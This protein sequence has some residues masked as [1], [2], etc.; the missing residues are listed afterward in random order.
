MTKADPYGNP[1]PVPPASQLAV[2]PFLAAV[3]GYLR[4]DQDVPDLRITVHRA[5][6]REGRDYLQQVCAYLRK[7]GGDWRGKV[8]RTFAVDTGII[9]AAYESGQLWRTKRFKDA[10]GLH[11]ALKKDSLSSDTVAQSWLAVPFLGPQDQVVLILYADCNK[12]NFF[13]DD[14][15]VKRIVAMSKGFCR[16]LDWLQKDPFENLRNFPLQKGDP[17]KG[18]G[19][20]YSVQQAVLNIGPPRFSSVPSFNYEAAAA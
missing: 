5:M 3:D 15:R 4:E 10:R 7:D 13:A 17:V 14:A 18:V 6:S 19:G 20:V 16:L 2:L 1:E 12:L 8:G 9:G 11:A